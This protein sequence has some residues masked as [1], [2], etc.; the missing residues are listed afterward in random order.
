MGKEPLVIAEDLAKVFCRDLRRSI[1]YGFQD[2]LR[3]LRG[4][5]LARAGQ[6]KAEFFALRNLSFTIPRGECIGVIGPNGAG[7]TTLLRLING[8]IKPDRGILKVRGQV[9]GII[10]LGAGFNPVLSG[11]ENIYVNAAVLGLSKRQT[12]RVVDEIIDFSEIREFIDMPVQSY[13]SGM[14]VRLGFSVAAH[15][16]PDV[17]LIDEV[18]AVGDAGFRAKC[19]NKVDE[20]R[21]DKAVLLVSHNMEH[22][23][24]V[25]DRV[26]VLDRGREVFFGDPGEG[27]MLYRSI[28]GAVERGFVRCCDPIKRCVVRVA[29]RDVAFAQPLE[30]ELGVFTSVPVEVRPRLVFFDN[31]SMVVAEGNS[32]VNDIDFCKLP[33]GENMLRVEIPALPLQ[34][35]SYAVSVNLYDRDDRLLVHGHRCLALSVSGSGHGETAVQLAFSMSR[36]S[37]S[38][39][40]VTE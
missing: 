20:L 29:R 39:R 31:H 32:L 17:L 15:L 24:R 38:A 11:R 14:T 1:A 37:P 36:G 3:E 16:E 22:V 19:Y 23:G 35:G 34:G 28:S 18:L 40:S 2:I 27:M 8:L 30:I 21:G 26:L 25:C 33:T 10:A 9:G 5:A 13:S 6:R 12:D 7:K 4:R